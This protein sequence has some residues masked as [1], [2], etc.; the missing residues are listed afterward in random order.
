MVKSEIVL[1]G[2]AHGAAHTTHTYEPRKLYRRTTFAANGG[3]QL[4][5]LTLPR[6]FSDIS[7]DLVFYDGVPEI[8]RKI[9]HG[10][11]VPSV[12][13][14]GSAAA[15]SDSHCNLSPRAILNQVNVGGGSRWRDDTH[16]NRLF[17]LFGILCGILLSQADQTAHGH[18]PS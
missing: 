16:S 11:H 7:A 14:V 6:A 18:A 4:C 3:S 8:V 13:L 5:D 2:R 9:A 12:L 17:E 10:T 15:D 1:A